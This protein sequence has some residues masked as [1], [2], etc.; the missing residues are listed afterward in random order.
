ML[1]QVGSGSSL[2]ALADIAFHIFVMLQQV[3]SGSSLNALADLTDWQT[4]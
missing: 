1:Q 2:N 3:G 4:D